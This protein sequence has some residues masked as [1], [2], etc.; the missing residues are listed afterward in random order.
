MFQGGGARKKRRRGGRS[1]AFDNIAG[2]HVRQ[3]EIQI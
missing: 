1:R 3:S 2:G